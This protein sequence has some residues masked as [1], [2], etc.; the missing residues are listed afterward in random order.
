M[1]ER[2]D[3][4]PVVC[5]VDIGSTNTKVVALGPD[6]AVLSRVRRRTPRG[7][8]DH[9]V[10]AAM[11]FDEIEEMIIEIC[12]GRFLVHGVSVAGVG[13]DGILVD[14]DLTPLSTALAWFD[15]QRR[16]LFTEI[17]DDLVPHPG[18]C[19]EDDPAR[20]MLGWL[21]ARRQ[22]GAQRA[23]SWVSL[24]DF[25]AVRWSGSLFLSDTL[26]A[27]T[28]AW[29]GHTRTWVDERVLLSLGEPAL[30]PPVVSTGEKIGPLRSHRLADA[31][32]LAEDALVVAGGHDHPIGGWGIHAMHPGAVLDSM[33]TAEVV[34]AQS[35][36]PDVARSEDLDVAPGICTSGTTVLSVQELARNVEWATDDDADVGSY[37]TQLIAGDV[38]PDD[39]I[40]DDTV[41]HAGGRGGQSPNFSDHAPA[42]ALSRASAVLGTLARMGRHGHERV[43]EQLTTEPASYAAGGWSR[44]PGWVRAKARATGHE[45][46]VIPE[47]QVTATACALIVAETIGW[48]PDPS[49]AMGFGPSD[50]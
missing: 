29:D 50:R 6:G 44:S 47:P 38:E 4:Q 42:S 12:G 8:T 26:A 34:V 3:L 48:S 11:L 49:L 2:S 24:T 17:E 15:P 39:F 46:A 1:S 27:R 14:A 13:E 9:G 37:L 5:G 33:G 25:P 41:F 30:L 18:L 10:D 40:F 43:A 16:T 19:T 45:V 35:P 20:T 36:H 28:A 21:W 23:A 7:T 32:V 31:G 22:P